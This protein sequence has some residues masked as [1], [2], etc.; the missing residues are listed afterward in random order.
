[1]L[2]ASSLLCINTC[3]SNK[4]QTCPHTP[5]YMLVSLALSVGKITSS[6]ATTTND[7]IKFDDTY[8]DPKADVILQSEDGTGY[9]V[10]SYLLKAHRCAQG[11]ARRAT[12]FS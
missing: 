10:H 4:L 3:I 2:L 11:S 8:A 1:M 9:R 12:S 5:P 7:D 6:T